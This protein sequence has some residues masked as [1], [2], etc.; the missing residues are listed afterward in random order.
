MSWNISDLE[1][2]DEKIKK[3]ALKHGL[4]WFPIDYEVCDY[5]E[6]MTEMTSQYEFINLY[7]LDDLNCYVK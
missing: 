6:M 1:M 7:V 3:I 4:D 5:Y 2:W